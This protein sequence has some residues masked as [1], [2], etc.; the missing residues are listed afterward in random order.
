MLI[1]IIVRFEYHIGSYNLQ[2]KLSLATKTC[3]I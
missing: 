1:K 2:F 3:E